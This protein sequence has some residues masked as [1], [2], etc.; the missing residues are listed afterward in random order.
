AARLGQG[1]A[2][3][4]R[5]ALHGEWLRPHGHRS[6]PVLVRRLSYDPGMQRVLAALVLLSA[7]A[8][9]D[10]LASSVAKLTP[11]Q[12][13]AIVPVKS[14]KTPLDRYRANVQAVAANTPLAALIRLNEANGPDV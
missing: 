13:V 4:R 7:V 14:G 9:A 1:P 2:P 10:P 3:R 8:S 12:V 5:R 11:D 6:D